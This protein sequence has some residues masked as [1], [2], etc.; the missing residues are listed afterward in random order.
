[1]IIWLTEDLTFVIA[2]LLVYWVSNRD[3]SF[4]ACA[5]CTLCGAIVTPLLLV[6]LF[7]LFN[8]DDDEVWGISGDFTALI[9][10]FAA[11]V[12]VTFGAVKGILQCKT[13]FHQCG[14]HDA[15]VLDRPAEYPLHPVAPRD[16]DEPEESAFST[17]SAKDFTDQLNWKSSFARS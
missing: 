17:M 6:V 11:Q 12:I 8:V 4:I 7:L 10:N 16:F 3:V 5:G 15:A 9:F 14:G 13:M 1:M 2:I